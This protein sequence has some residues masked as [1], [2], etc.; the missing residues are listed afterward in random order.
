MDRFLLMNCFARAVETGS[1]SAVAREMGVGQPNVSRY[2]AALEDHLGTRLLHRSTRKLTLTPEGERYY[3]EAR[4]VLDALTEAESNARGEDKPSGLLRVACPTT[5]GRAYV[6]P[7]IQ[8]LLTRYPQMDVDLQ[9]SDRFVDL[10]EEGVD[11]AMR[12]GDLKDSALRAVR[13][14]IS[15]RLC[16]ASPDYLANHPPPRIPQDLAN[17]DCIVYSLF[18]TPNAWQ[19]RDGPVEVRGRFKVNT[20]D[21]VQTAALAGMGVGIVPMWLAEES[22]L[23]GRLRLLLHDYIAPP[24][25][26]NIVYAAKRLLPSR[27]RVF[28]QF[29]AAEFAAIPA[30][31]EGGLQR[32]LQAG[33]YLT[34]R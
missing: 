21:G 24:V 5:I 32:L 8:T 20:T 3:S 9:I 14:G 31:N 16:V 17:H 2:I 28:M 11:L 22:L 29:M 13:I 34:S 18:A 33:L 25:P 27:A 12:I 19:F 30:I 15:E 26:I 7:R 10:T 6:L 23:S 1:F 4:R